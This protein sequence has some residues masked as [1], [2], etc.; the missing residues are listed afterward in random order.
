[1]VEDTIKALKL[2]ACA[3]TIV[4]DERHRGKSSNALT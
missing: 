3:N 1:V 2:D 4:G